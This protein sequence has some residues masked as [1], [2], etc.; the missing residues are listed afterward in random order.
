MVPR[1]AG[2]VEFFLGAGHGTGCQPGGAHDFCGEGYG[3]HAACRCHALIGHCGG[4]HVVTGPV[5]PASIQVLGRI[6][7]VPAPIQVPAAG[8]QIGAGALCG[9]MYYDGRISQR[10]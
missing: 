5:V 9:H 3:V 7:G 2:E 8:Q 4:V 6:R 1:L 10:G